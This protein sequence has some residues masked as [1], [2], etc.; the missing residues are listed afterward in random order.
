MSAIPIHIITP[1]WGAEYSRLFAD[2]CLPTLLAPG[3]IPALAQTPGCVYQIY[4]TPEDRKYLEA[5]AALAT[6]ARYIRVEFHNIHD[7][8]GADPNRYDV[9]SGCYRRGMAIADAVDAAMIFV[10]ADVVMADG[11]IRTLRNLAESGKRAVLAMGVRLNKQ[12]AWAEIVAGRH[13]PR[14]GTVSISASELAAIAVANLHQISRL[15]L[16]RGTEEEMHPAG[17]FWQVGREGLLMRCFHLHPLL[18]RPKY[19]NTSFKGAIDDDYLLAACP[20]IADIHIIQNSDDLLACELSEEM[21][22]IPARPRSERDI[23]IAGWAYYNANNQHREYVK[24]TIYMHVAGIDSPAWQAA[25]RESD[26]VIARVLQKLYD[27]NLL[28]EASP[29]APPAPPPPPAPPKPKQSFTAIFL[30]GVLPLLHTCEN[31]ALQTFRE[32]RTAYPKAIGGWIIVIASA[33]YLACFWPLRFI[34]RWI[35]RTR[36]LLAG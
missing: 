3:N 10:N 31:A 18:V 33:L 25:Q 20:D 24:T 34:G 32:L 7:D 11:G 8:V 17:L 36:R 6:L 14:T 27:P 5:S 22:R 15:H 28:A 35:S 29:E 23:D 16:Y 30:Y 2:L 12:A 1:V 13:D 4:T 9:Q 21:R 26:G 19:K